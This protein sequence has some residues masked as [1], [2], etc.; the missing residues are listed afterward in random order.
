MDLRR[1]LIPV[2]YSPYSLRALRF[3]VELAGQL[4]ASVDIV[5]VWDK[6]AYISAALLSPS[7]TNVERA[8]PELIADQAQQ[9]LEQFLA[10]S[11]LPGLRG[12]LLAGEPKKQILEELKSG[13][14]DLVVVGTH[15]RSGLSH[16]V[17]GSVA[18]TL[19]RL[20]PIPVLT[21]PIPP[22]NQPANV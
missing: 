6:P 5:H 9:D 21:V 3:G 18:E 10:S 16:L 15:G 11:E 8:L 17:L 2:D 7:P 12:R 20:S 13:R 1:I 19:T 4:Q 14:H 22:A